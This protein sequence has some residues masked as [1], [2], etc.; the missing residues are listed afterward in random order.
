MARKRKNTPLKKLEKQ[1][2]HIMHLINSLVIGG[3]EVA[4]LNYIQALGQEDYEHYVY[5]FGHDGPIRKKVED[6]GAQV[7]FGP[8]RASIKNPFKFS[9]TLL[10]LV[11]DLLNFIKFNKIHLIHSHLGQPNQLAVLIGKLSGISAF[12]TIHS[13]NAFEDTRSSWDPRVY[14]IKMVN[15][16]IY[17]MAEQVVVVS[18]KIKD[19]IRQ[20]YGL[21]DSQVVVLKNGIIIEDT[22]SESQPLRQDFSI[23]KNKL[24]IVAVGRL[25]PLKC[26]DTLVKAVAKIV[27]Q[28]QN[29][30]LVLIIGDGEERPRLEKLI[31]ELRLES[32]V[33]LLGLRHDVIELLGEAD[34]FVIPS[35]YEGLSIAM[36]EAMACGLSIIGSNAPGLRECIN[37]GQNGLLFQVKDHNALA[38]CILLLAN[39]KM[40]LEK[41]SKGAKDT[42]EREYDIRENIKPLDALFRK[43]VKRPMKRVN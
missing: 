7:Y 43:C 35:S 10:V 39:N 34:I 38:E 32:Y 14:F 4:L 21:E 23:S 1:K 9:I 8:K 24:K 33:K 13:T 42:F 17:R 3:A 19:I 22:F 2:I 20:T 16:I 30:L 18:P 29:N 15:A 36:I 37:H 41:L 5:S 31:A 6:L 27:E 40:L 11:K 25:V 28:G 26:F 12:P